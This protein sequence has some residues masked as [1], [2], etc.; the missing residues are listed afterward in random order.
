MR[1]GVEFGDE[2]VDGVRAV[3][4]IGDLAAAARGIDE[5]TGLPRYAEDIAL[6]TDEAAVAADAT[7]TSR[8]PQWLKDRLEAGR[9]FNRDNWS[10]YDANEVILGNGKI[11]DSCSLNGEN[12]SRKLTQ[13]S[14]V[15]PGTARQYLNEL[16]NKYSPGE[17]VAA[18]PSNE[19]QF[20]TSM[21]G[22]PIR[23]QLV[24]EVPVQNLPVPQTVLDKAAELNVVIR[25]VSGRPY[26]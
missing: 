21:I 22:K 7:R 8:M 18:K 6:L 17:V 19:R 12:V 11:L 16:V 4:N 23:G 9:Q 3:D 10:R 25:D 20:P 5:V 24:L 14:D 1:H 26:P 15:Q 2:I 13:L